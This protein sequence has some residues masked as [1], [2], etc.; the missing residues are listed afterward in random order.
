MIGLAAGIVLVVVGLIVA[1]VL[2]AN[3]NS[4]TS[5]PPPPSSNKVYCTA[6][7]RGVGAC[8]MEHAPVCGWNDETVQCVT[9]PCAQTYSNKCMACTNEHVAYYTQG[10]C[11]TSQT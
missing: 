1:V 4:S 11:P 7:S 2:I 3:A 9:Y 5:A 8:T 10:E 6:E